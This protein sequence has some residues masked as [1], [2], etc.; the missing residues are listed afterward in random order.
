MALT[1]SSSNF[2]NAV[3]TRFSPM[4]LQAEGKTTSLE[5]EPCLHALHGLSLH[6]VLTSVSWRFQH[7]SEESCSCS[8]RQFA[9]KY[10][11]WYAMTNSLTKFSHCVWIKA[12]GTTSGQKPCS[13]RRMVLSFPSVPCSQ[14]NLYLE[15]PEVHLLGCALHVLMSGN[16]AFVQYCTASL[17]IG[18]S[19]HI[20]M[21]PRCR[22]RYGVMKIICCFK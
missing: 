7:I 13:Y 12:S 16:T 21:K 14:L 9:Q 11:A 22:N 1:D 8:Q 3:V 17:D 4:K 15:G 20:K 5:K 6:W 19:P 2:S 10:V 18:P